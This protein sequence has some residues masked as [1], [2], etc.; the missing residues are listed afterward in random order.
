MLV[1]VTV[2]GFGTY[3]FY[4][5]QIAQY[6]AP[7]ARQLPVVELSPED[8]QELETRVET[9][10]DT[11]A[12]GEAP[13][14][15]VLDSEDLNALISQEQ[16]LRGRVFVTISD[17]LIQAEVSFPADAIPGAKGRYFNA[18]ASINAS[19]RDGELVVTLDKAEANGLEVPEAVMQGLRQQNLAKDANKNPELA[20]ILG[21]FESL[22][23]E[24]D[25]LIL[26][27][28]VQAPSDEAQAQAKT[29]AALGK[30]PQMETQ[31]DTEGDAAAADTDADASST[32]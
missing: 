10:Q 26:T 18:S 23:I 5:Q 16:Q 24:G 30:Q 14:P 28:K 32:P 17:G 6:T 11:V 9:F 8:L 7:E 29:E 22:A 12:Q 15:L 2:A 25:K 20:E 13:A 31:A 19:L 1:L 21:Q 27:P 3:R 4:K